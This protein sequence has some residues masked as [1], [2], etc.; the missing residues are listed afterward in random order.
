MSQTWKLLEN[1]PL[2]SMIF[3]GTVYFWGFPSSSP[4][5][6]MFPKPQGYPRIIQVMDDHDLV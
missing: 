3:L 6:P 4:M 2:S 5:E 1:P